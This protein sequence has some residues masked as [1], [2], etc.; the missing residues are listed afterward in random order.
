MEKKLTNLEVQEFL[1]DFEANSETFILEEGSKEKN[2]LEKIAEARGIKVK[3]SRDLAV[4][5]T[6]YAFTDVP[7][8]N[9]AILPKAELLRVLPQIVGKPININ[10]ERRF[11]VGHYID[12]RY[13]QKDSQINAYGIYYKSNFGKEFEEAK[14]LLKKKKLSSSFEIW[15]PKDKRKIKEDGS[16]ELHQ[17]EIAGGALIY[18]DKNNEPAFK[19]AKVL[20]IG[21]QQDS[22]NLELV[23]A[24]KYKEDEIITCK[25]DKCKLEKAQETLAPKETPAIAKIKCSNCGEEFDSGVID[26]IKCPKCFAILDKSGNMIYPPQIIDFKMLCPSCSTNNWLILSKK[27]DKVK[28]RCSGCSKEYN[29]SFATEQKKDIIDKINFV[30][31]SKVS[32]LQCHKPIYVLGTSTTKTKNVKC[33]KCGLEFSY[34]ITHDRYKKISK[35]E[36]V[37]PEK[38]KI[39]NAKESSEEG[40]QKMAKEKKVEKVS[41]KVED[42]IIKEFAEG[43]GKL[44]DKEMEKAKEKREKEVKEIPKVEKIKST[45]KKE[46]E[47][48]KDE[49]KKEE[50]VAKE[51]PK[52]EKAQETPVEPVK[53]EKSKTEVKETPKAEEPKVEAKIE[54]K[55]EKVTVEKAEEPIKETTNE[56]VK[57]TI[58]AEEPKEDLSKEDKPIEAR[59]EYKVETLD[60]KLEEVEPAELDDSA[61]M[62]YQQRKTLPDNMFAVVV[63]VKD[64]RTGKSRKIRKYPIND[65][66]HVRNALARLG[67]PKSKATL[68]KL[69]V[70]LEAVRRKVLR[71]ARQ[72]KMT[73]L[74]E[75]YKSGVRKVAT[76]VKELRKEKASLEKKVEL[77][78][79]KAKTILERQAELGEGCE[80][81]EEEI[82]NDDKFGKVKAEKEL[83]KAKAELNKGNDIVGAKK[84]LRD[85][86]WYADKR[87]AIDRE[88]FKHI[89]EKK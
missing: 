82:L 11:V 80:L 50:S 57:S 85:E 65:E 24:S 19:D 31:S 2:E 78:K 68:Q 79:N 76:R 64:K 61:R 20:A 21:K 36:E 83:A 69:G 29:L 77:Y 33:K 8:S 63:T 37:I 45:D 12:Y 87:N 70:S 3:D 86:K 66:P 4:F 67:Q 43:F 42:K 13:K 62:T 25:G 18:E 51:T 84:L 1:T 74:L 58:K 39:D 6:I 40:G 81:T 71:R 7:N 30:Y 9:G 88:A 75:R 59:F 38:N 35:I 41:K 16:Y 60:E 72:L 27:E 15:S 56:E 22:P 89:N 32:C 5:K 23:Y 52:T 14:K 44:V 34:D 55:E 54:K 73:Q 48:K 28:V 47:S 26:K 49:V 53:E 17:M 46:T 10:H